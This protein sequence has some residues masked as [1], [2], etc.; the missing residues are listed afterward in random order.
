[1]NRSYTNFKR[2]MPLAAAYAKEHGWELK[3][4]APGKQSLVKGKFRC[5]ISYTPS[6]GNADK[7]IVRQLKKYDATGDIHGCPKETNA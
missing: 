5:A 6:D 1:M 7:V 3:L 4:G 2:R